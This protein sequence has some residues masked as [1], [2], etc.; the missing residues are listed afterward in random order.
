[1]LIFCLAF[2]LIGIFL[3]SFKNE[4]YIEFSVT[5][6]R[7]VLQENSKII[8]D[9]NV[10]KDIQHI[11]ATYK[12]T[13][14]NRK[15]IILDNVEII[16]EY[17]KTTVGEYPVTLRAEYKGF[18]DEEKVIIWVRDVVCPVITLEGEPLITLRAG[19]EYIEP[20]FTAVDDYDGDITD[21][22]IV[23]GMVRPNGSSYLEYEVT[24]S[25][26]NTQVVKRG[27]TIEIEEDQKIIYLTFDDGPTLYTQRLLDVLDRYNAK[28][29]FFVT[30]VKEE[31][32]DRIGEAYDRGHTIALHSFSHEYS[33]YSDSNTFY[34]DLQ[35]IESLVAAQTGVK[36]TIF[37]FPGGTANTVSKRH[38][39]GIMKELVETLP[40]HG[41][42]YCDWNVSSGDG[43]GAKDEA[44]VINNVI[45]GIQRL[46]KKESAIVLM[47]DT[48]S[49]S[50]DAV[51]DI[52]EWGLANG[53]TFLPL[54]E[55]S[56]L[57][58][59]KPIN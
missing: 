48:R 9:Y 4:P 50:V 31:Y 35:K 7:Q 13:I 43:G 32:Y 6:E 40:S 59:Q 17:D 12:E 3:L 10:D 20:G 11:T 5:E 45:N 18:V 53:Y 37:R 49:F 34:E 26:G 42:T 52:I 56:P 2:V 22:V 30:G 33:I 39:E 57:V 21:Q 14:F 38:C 58:Q 44:T 24:D 46:G 23:H 41:Y 36:P 19:E 28:A 25:N 47:H 8:M 54:I 27:I 1:M 15:G 16:G 55:E 51:D 29:T